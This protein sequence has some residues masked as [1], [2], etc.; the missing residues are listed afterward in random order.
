MR[1]VA[2]ARRGG[3]AK[4][5]PGTYEESEERTCLGKVRCIELFPGLPSSRLARRAWMC[6]ARLRTLLKPHCPGNLRS[7]ALACAAGS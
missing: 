1:F 6:L 2:R 5:V 4:G 3:Y 7:L